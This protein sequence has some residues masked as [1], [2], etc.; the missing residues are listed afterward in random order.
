MKKILLF[1][2]FLITSIS[3]CYSADV[4]DNNLGRALT[5]IFPELSEGYIDL[6]N[7]G[8][9]DRLDDMD[10]LVPDSRVKD[11]IIQVQEILDFIGENYPFFFLD[12]LIAVRDALDTT[13][14][15]IPELIALSY[16][17]TIR[18]IIRKKEELGT[19]GLYLSPSAKKEAQ[20]RMAGL[21]A[22]MVSAY[23]NETARDEQLFIDARDK[24]FTMI[25]QGYPIVR[26]LPDEDMNVLVSA[27]IQTI[28]NE[29]DSSEKRVKSAVKT[30]GKL[31]DP[32]A[33]P[34][35][36]DL[37]KRE[38]Y[39]LE[40]IR[41][42]GEIGNAEAENT[43]IQVLA[44]ESSVNVREAALKALGRIGGEESLDLLIS[45]LVEVKGN[46]P[47]EEAAILHA[48]SGMAVGGNSDRRISGVLTEYISSPDPEMRILAARG[49]AALANQNN[50]NLLINA[51]R[52]E[53]DEDV[54]VELIKSL[55]ATGA[56]QVVGVLINMLR[57]ES[58]SPELRRVIIEE[59]GKIAEGVRAIATIQDYLGNEDKDLRKA[60]HDSL[61]SLYDF[62][63][64]AVSGAL[65]RIA[66]TVDD[67]LYLAETAS[68][69]AQLADPDTVSGLMNLLKSPFGEVKKY[70]TWALYRIGEVNNARMI[71]DLV[72]IATS[73]TEPLDVRINAV[74]TLGL[75]DDPADSV[76]QTLIT[77]VKMRG[78]KY[79]MLRYFAIQALGKLR[80]SQPE[81]VGTL[82][83]VALRENNLLIKKE[84]LASIRKIGLVIEG[85]SGTLN[86]VFRRSDDTEVKTLVVEAMGDMKMPEAADLAAVL[87]E[88]SLTPAVKQRLAYALAAG[89]SEKAMNQLIGLAVDEDVSE[90]TVALLED[91][92]SRLM[93]PLV[94]KRLRSE[95]D[96]EIAAILEDLKASYESQY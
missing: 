14:G 85:L 52:G 45:R 81:A 59:L 77:T 78:E 83:Q 22:D 30:L 94:D 47:K 12:D 44:S 16:N 67:E 23:K 54:T 70:A 33:V 92:P 79:S 57:D 6:N 10:E 56:V 39:K 18:E 4:V 69:L 37:M 26:N 19:D 48:L 41:A 91:M 72:G 62:N 53:R 28:L 2:A 29:R 76:T 74:R 8:E 61:L 50:L 21:I 89:G 11:N 60:A 90:L 55:S 25:E 38:E 34:Y 64:K 87:L 86:S 66:L 51:L 96:D 73:E 32:F 46:S 80:V 63:P 75:V 65:T 95:S 71:A 3:L 43:L 58:T 17:R 36:L 68:I 35:I 27:L 24:L 40:G 88:E 31:Q 9:L 20:D 84:A 82:S 7:N 1:T 5:G 49:L 15:T 13:E 42:L 93:K